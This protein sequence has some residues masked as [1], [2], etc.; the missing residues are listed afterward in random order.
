MGTKLSRGQEGINVRSAGEVGTLTYLRT[1]GDGTWSWEPTPM[2]FSWGA[3]MRLAGVSAGDHVTVPIG[4]SATT[5][6]LNTGG[7]NVDPALSYSISTTADNMNM[8]IVQFP[9]NIVVDKIQAQVG[10]G[11]ANN[12]T[13]N[14]HVIKYTLAT[15]GTGSSGAVVAAG[16]ILTT[17]DYAHRRYLDLTIVGGEEDVNSN[18]GLIGFIEMPTAVNTYLSCRFMMKFFMNTN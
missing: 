10:Q 5:I 14:F 17:D 8:R 6:T 15:D 3:A 4:Y 13:H 16:S 11:G 18:E 9:E 7:L 1:A 2:Y 12:T